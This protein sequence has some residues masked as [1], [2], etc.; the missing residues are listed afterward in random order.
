MCS[1]VAPS[2]ALDVEGERAVAD[3]AFPHPVRSDP[4]EAGVGFG[5][6][7][8]SLGGCHGF[9]GARKR[10]QQTQIGRNRT[11]LSG[12]ERSACLQVGSSMESVR[13]DTVFFLAG[14]CFTDHE[15]LADVLERQQSDG[16]PFLDH[17]QARSLSFAK[18][19]HGGNQRA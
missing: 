3:Q 10:D 2:P 5:H 1:S 16:S 9:W 13:S 12:R 8:Q 11:S 4:A 19:G 18:P 7:A 15:E 17:L 14:K 6:V